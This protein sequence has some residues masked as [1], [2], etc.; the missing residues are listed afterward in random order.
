MCVP[1][2]LK[3]T[4]KRILDKLVAGGQVECNDGLLKKQ[5]R[6]DNQR[7]EEIEIHINALFKAFYSGSIHKIIFL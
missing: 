2:C 1:Q 3:M 5:F 7:Y 6:R 4:V